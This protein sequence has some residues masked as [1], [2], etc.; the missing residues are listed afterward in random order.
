[1]PFQYDI[2]L[3]LFKGNYFLKIF[4]ELFLKSDRLLS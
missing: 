3:S 2:W 4:A 1:M